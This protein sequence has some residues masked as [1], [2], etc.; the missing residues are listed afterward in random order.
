[1][2][3]PTMRSDPFPLALV[4]GS[5]ATRIVLQS[6]SSSRR[7]SSGDHGWRNAARSI[8]ITSSR[9]AGD[10]PRISNRARARTATSALRSHGGTI[11]RIEH[12]HR[13]AL[14]QIRQQLGEQALVL[15]LREAGPQRLALERRQPDSLGRL[16]QLAVAQLRGQ[17][18]PVVEIAGH[19]QLARE[20]AADLFVVQLHQPG[21]GLVVRLGG[22]AGPEAGQERV[23]LALLQVEELEALQLRQHHPLLD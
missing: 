17:L 18:E 10:I 14:A 13:G 7:N 12:P 1:M 22:K 8:T 5:T 2:R 15:L 11:E 20:D 9:S 23:H 4:S 16:L 6:C 3:K 21:E 19:A